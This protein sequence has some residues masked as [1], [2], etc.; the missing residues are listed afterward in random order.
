GACPGRRPSGDAVFALSGS[1]SPGP[2]YADASGRRYFGG[3][4]DKTALGQRGLDVACFLWE[5]SFNVLRDRA[6][7]RTLGI[8][9]TYATL[10]I[11]GWLV[12]PTG[13]LLWAWVA[14]LS[15]S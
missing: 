14:V 8:L 7:I 3:R 4:S 15:Y 12:A 11:A 9:A 6:D 2:F 13:P 1:R 10:F 5:G